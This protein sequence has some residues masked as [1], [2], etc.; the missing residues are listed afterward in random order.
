MQERTW[1]RLSLT[2][3][4]K[5]HHCVHVCDQDANMRAGPSLRAALWGGA[6][7]AAEVNVSSGELMT[8]KEEERQS[9]G[10]NHKT[11]VILHLQPILHG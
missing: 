10:N 2:L 7:A 9:S 1:G 8:V 11:Q 3:C 6:M 5:K 4:I